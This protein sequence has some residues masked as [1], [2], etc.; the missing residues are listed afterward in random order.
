MRNVSEK[1]CK[2]NKNTHFIFSN[3]FFFENRDVYELMWKKYNAAG[4]ATDNSMA[5]AHCLLDT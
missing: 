3:I 2:E 4:H 5:H 1:C